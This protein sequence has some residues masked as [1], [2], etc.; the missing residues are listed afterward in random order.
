MR[1]CGANDD[2]YDY[3]TVFTNIFLG[4]CP[5][6]LRDTYDVYSM[7]FRKTLAALTASSLGLCSGH[8]L[9]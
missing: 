6:N 9:G 5:L 3:I 1:H 4:P 8:D 2:V 7:I